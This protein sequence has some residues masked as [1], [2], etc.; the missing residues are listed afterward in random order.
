MVAAIIVIL[1]FVGIAHLQDIFNAASGVRSSPTPSNPY[2]IAGAN[3]MLYDP[4]T[5]NSKGAGWDE[6]NINN[7][8]I[9][10]LDSSG[11]IDEVKMGF[12]AICG[13]K[14]PSFETLRNYIF[15]VNASFRLGGND[16]LYG[17]VIRH[18]LSPESSYR[19]QIT[20]SGEYSI[21]VER[22]PGGSS[23]LHSG[24]ITTPFNRGPDS[25]NTLAV[26]ANGASFTLYVNHMQVMT[27]QDSSLDTGSIGV[28]A[29]SPRDVPE[30]E[31]VYTF[32]RVW[33]L[34]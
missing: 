1:Q 8:V 31:V 21:V 33:Q 4:M 13:A 15:E 12:S 32:A 6:I 30:T 23:V 28:Y 20:P 34:P 11:Y 17:I 27:F 22:N 29:S 25:Y 2:N 3:L 10:K 26:V 14:S 18:S 9:C 16:S 24:A 7:D 5:D 19:F